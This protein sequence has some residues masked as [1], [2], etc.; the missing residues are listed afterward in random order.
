MHPWLMEQV[1]NERRRDL[2]GQAERH[3]LRRQ[4]PRHSRTI[5]PLR[6][7][8]DHLGS[9]VGSTRRRQRRPP[10]G[11]RQRSVFLQDGL[12]LETDLDLVADDHTAAVKGHVEFDPEVAPAD[13]G[14]R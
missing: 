6:S 9:V 3:R 11:R 13:L 4:A 10:R 1:A 8:V 12:D 5:G 2:L 7:L 14:S